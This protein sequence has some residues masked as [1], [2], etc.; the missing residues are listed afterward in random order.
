MRRSAVD[1]VMGDRFER[2]S[3][4]LAVEPDEPT[5]QQLAVALGR[6]GYH[7]VLASSGREAMARFGVA[8]PNLVLLEMSLPDF[9]GVAICRE[10]RARSTVPI[11]LVSA[12]NDEA[13][14]VDGL[15]AG[16]DHYVAKPYRPR[17]L[18]ARIRAAMRRGGP[19][20]AEDVVLTI[21]SV[22]LDATRHEVT[23]RGRR[24]DLAL[25]EFDL[26]EVLMATAGRV[27]PRDALMRRVWGE[28]PRSG[29]KSLD[30][31]VKRIRKKIEDDPTAPTKL[32]T[33][34][35]VGYRYQTV[36]PQH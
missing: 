1:A 32:L 36:E 35:G 14:A 18:V 3:T 23:V 5:A 13:D 29:T 27:W 28:L 4:I 20:A 21:G 17:E 30:V 33:V 15:D 10:I 24:V 6:E 7:V 8:K 25:R 2:L 34:R 19:S 26:L 16:A 12:G 22:A 11:I 9:A 31:H